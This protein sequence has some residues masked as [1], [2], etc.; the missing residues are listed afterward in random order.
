LK[1][2]VIWYG[3]ITLEILKETPMKSIKVKAHYNI[4]IMYPLS[5][6]FLANTKN[7]IS[8]VFLIIRFSFDL[9]KVHNYHLVKV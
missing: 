2:V 4:S 9:S 1:N 3:E 6:I 5:I 7:L 8:N